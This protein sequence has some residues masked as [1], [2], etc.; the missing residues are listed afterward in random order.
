MK[1][2]AQIFFTFLSLILIFFSSCNTVPFQTEWNTN[3]M[4][5]E[6]D[7]KSVQKNGFIVFTVSDAD[8]RSKY[9]LDSVFTK[10]FFETASQ[11]FSL[12]N[13]NIVKDK[14]LMSSQD[15]ERN[16]IL[17]KNYEVLDVPSLVLLNEAGDVYHLQLIPNNIKTTDEFLKYLNELYEKEAK[18]ISSLKNKID[19]VAG[20]EKTKAIYDFIQKLYL[21]G[22]EKYIPLLDLAIKN[23]PENK[24]GLIGKLLMAKKQIIIEKLLLEKKFDNAIKEFMELIDSKT[25]APEEEQLTW[26]NIIYV[27][28]VTANTSK[29]QTIKY[30]QKALNAAPNSKRAKDIKDDIIYLKNK[31]N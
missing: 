6:K 7:L 9:L 28:S 21:A 14:S 1:F 20:I 25:L 18:P 26:L 31:N 4:E 3:A 27:Y 17:L 30:L 29:E 2:K 12:Y 16:Y 23:D 8:D 11:R 5:I 15:L 10:E 24:T 13:V 22:T 19:E